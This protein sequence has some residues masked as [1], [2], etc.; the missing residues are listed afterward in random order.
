MDSAISLSYAAFIVLSSR[1]SCSSQKRGRL[2]GFP[3]AP[4]P[5][6]K[7]RASFLQVAARLWRGRH[8]LLGVPRASLSRTQA[9]LQELCHCDPVS[10]VAPTCPTMLVQQGWGWGLTVFDEGVRESPSVSVCYIILLPFACLSLAQVTTKNWQA[11]PLSLLVLL[12]VL[13]SKPTP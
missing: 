11:Q 7:A 1:H 9:R 12:P 2:K 4:C 13:E 10:A 6:R 8:C 5:G 3:V